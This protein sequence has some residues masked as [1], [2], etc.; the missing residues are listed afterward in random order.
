MADLG[1]GF[2]LV[3]FRKYICTSD[4]ALKRKLIIILGLSFAG[5]YCIVKGY[6][7]NPKEVIETL[8]HTSDQF[9]SDSCDT[10]FE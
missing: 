8:T 5:Y 10:S 7:T 4:V 1:S 3:L 9:Q 6:L 2:G